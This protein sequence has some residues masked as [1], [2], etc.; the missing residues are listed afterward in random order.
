[1]PQAELNFSTFQSRKQIAFTLAE[2]LI[3]ITI[4]GIVAALTVPTLIK[5]YQDKVLETRYKKAKNIVT[6]GY[7]LM[8]ANEQIFNAAQLPFLLN[9]SN[10]PFVS[11]EHRNVYK[12]INEYYDS[13]KFP[14]DIE[15][16]I[17][18]SDKSSPFSWDDVPYIFQVSDGMLYGVLK[19]DDAETFSLFVDTNNQTNPNT[20][21]KD[22]F[23]F[24]VSGNAHLADVSD[25]LEAVSV[26]SVDDYSKCT[27]DEC[28][29]L[30]NTFVCREGRTGPFYWYDWDDWETPGCKYSVSIANYCR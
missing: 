30:N 5:K 2:V 11:S 20:V 7:R 9:F 19:D 1:M 6:N 10:L 4:I 25:E 24:R 13:K 21:K 29:A 28:Y 15:Y 8:M 12:V 17:T 27:E 23:K 18:D 16:A 26:C 14:Y 3:T 22:M